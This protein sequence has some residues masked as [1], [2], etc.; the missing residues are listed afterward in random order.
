MKRAIVSICPLFAIMVQ[1]AWPASA[2]PLAQVAAT[3]S[4][5]GGAALVGRPAPPFVVMTLDGKQVSLAD[6]KGKPLLVNFWATWCA[7]CKLE[8]PWL[9]ELR[10][11][12][13]GQGFEIIGI[14][15]DSATD[16]KVRQIAAK[17]GVEYR[18]ARCN[19]KTAQAYGGL[20]YLPESFYID[21]RGKVVLTAAD[22]SSKEEIEANIRKLL[23]LGAR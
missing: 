12:Y 11:K 17:Y 3:S 4:T 20:S 18:L 6:Y 5:E 16:E 8:M 14:V 13:A 21:K 22:A 15:T 7:A 23:G 19:H 2:P 10:E 9:A 1:P